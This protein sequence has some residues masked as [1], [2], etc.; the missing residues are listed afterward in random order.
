MIFRRSHDNTQS[1]SSMY[2]YHKNNEIS[3]CDFEKDL[4]WHMWDLDFFM[5]YT[6]KQQQ[7]QQY[8]EEEEPDL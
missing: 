4:W 6:T 2:P 5:R 3:F 1:S 8:R 7:Q